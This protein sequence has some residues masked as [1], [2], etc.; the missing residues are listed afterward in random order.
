M[1]NRVEGETATEDELYYAQEFHQRSRDFVADVI[2]DPTST[3]TVTQDQLDDTTFIVDGLTQTLMTPEEADAAWVLNDEVLSQTLGMNRTQ[4]I[5]Y[6]NDQAV[7]KKVYDTIAAVP[8]LEL[9]P[10]IPLD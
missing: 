3:A 1:K 6:M 9:H 4:M 10:Q 8:T 5:A 7:A 2:A